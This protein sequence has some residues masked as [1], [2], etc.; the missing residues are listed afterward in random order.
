MSI[1]CKN[2]IASLPVNQ[3]THRCKGTPEVPGRLTT[4]HLVEI[5]LPADPKFAA[6]RRALSRELAGRFGGVTAFIRAPAKGLFAQDGEQVQ[7]DIVVL[8]VMTGSLERD[9]WAALRVRLEDDFRQDAV[10]MR[11]TTVERL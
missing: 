3:R 4:M 7:D 9:W 10:L 11:A 2:S 1:G 5:F 8:E 6:K